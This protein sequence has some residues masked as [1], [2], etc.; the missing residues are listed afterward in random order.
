MLV[1]L[2]EASV[3]LQSQFCI[4]TSSV[5][6]PGAPPELVGEKAAGLQESIDRFICTTFVAEN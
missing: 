6:R 1:P 5:C 2:S 3:L 4:G